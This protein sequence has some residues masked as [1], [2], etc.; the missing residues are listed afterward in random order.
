MHRS[1]QVGYQMKAVNVPDMMVGPIQCKKLKL[2][3]A[4]VI[5]EAEN[6]EISKY[7][8]GPFFCQSAAL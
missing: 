1:G 3:Q 7:Y 8:S 5:Y 2:V 6:D 4:E